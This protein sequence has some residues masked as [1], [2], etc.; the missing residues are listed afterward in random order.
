MPA[1]A[2][3]AAA[4]AGCAY[5]PGRPFVPPPADVASPL[6]ADIDRMNLKGATYPSFIDVPNLPTD[7]RPVTA[8]T[9]NI[10]NV[11]RTRREMQAI[12]VLD[13]QS[14]YGAEA[15][16]QEGRAYA[17]PPPASIEPTV[18]PSKTAAFATQGHERA[19]PPSPA[20]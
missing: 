12:V 5:L 20:Q 18:Q 10:Y 16:A 15:F 14:L 4:L 7:V 13:P 9:R 2:L 3:A 1:A 19:K 6:A 17:A 11:L 8:W